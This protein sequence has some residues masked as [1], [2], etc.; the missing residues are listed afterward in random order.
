MGWLQWWRCKSPVTQAITHASH[1][2][3][4]QILGKCDKTWINRGLVV[5]IAQLSHFNSVSIVYWSRTFSERAPEFWAAQNFCAFKIS[6]ARLKKTWPIRAHSQHTRKAIAICA[7]FI[8]T[9]SWV[10]RA[11]GAR[12]SASAFDSRQFHAVSTMVARL[13]RYCIATKSR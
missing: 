3:I 7:H 13:Y 10:R 1:I 4:D 12:S 8:A 9:Q 2:K 5:V 6:F 11:C